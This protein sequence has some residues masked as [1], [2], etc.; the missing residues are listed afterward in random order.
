MSKLREIF[1]Q[2]GITK[3]TETETITNVALDYLSSYEEFSKE[4]VQ[5]L[6][7]VGYT[8]EEVEQIADMMTEDRGEA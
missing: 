8:K 2:E 3:E 6:T 5:V 4:D 7:E 1:K